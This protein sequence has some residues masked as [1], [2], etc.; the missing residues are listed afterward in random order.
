[1]H[2]PCSLVAL[3]VEDQED[4]RAIICR[5]LRDRGHKVYEAADATTGL[6]LFTAHDIGIV[7]CDLG[8]PDFDGV[9]LLR[10]MREIKWVKT[11]ALTGDRWRAESDAAQS[12]DFS[13]YLIKPTNLQQL[14]EAVEAA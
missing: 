11:I 9:E 3:V 5:L 12:S 4:S 13:D 7:I 8:L 6:A 10:R 14:M 1:M 2:R